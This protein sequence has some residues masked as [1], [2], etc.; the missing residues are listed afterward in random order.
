MFHTI[1]ISHLIN[2]P[3]KYVPVWVDRFEDM[4]EP[5]NLLFPHKHSFYE[6][7]WITKGKSNHTIDYKNYELEKNTL[8]FI[9]PGQLHLF[10][11]WQDIEG[12][13][14]LFTE[15]FFSQIFQNKNI[16]FELS[17]LDNLYSNPFLKIGDEEKSKLQPIVD[18][19]LKEKS[20]ESVQALLF[21]LL[22]QIQSLYLSNRA[23]KN[24]KNQIIIFKKFKNLVEQNFNK[25]LS[26]TEY[27]NQLNI[28]PN[29]LNSVVKS[30]CNKT[31]SHIIDERIVLEAKQLLQFSD[32]NI[33]QITD[34][35][36]F[37]DSSYFARYFKKHTSTSPLEFRKLHLR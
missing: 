26:L 30:I 10:E 11:D 37:E 15:G 29:T 23:N 16:L 14:I 36:G 6:I 22:K 12:Y 24:S 35:L 25:Y 32:D 8:F 17:Y 27:A 21:V 31:A 34:K 28:S 18:L 33:S 2:Q 1:S 5:Q 19:L 13:C 9:S 20:E 7:L 3:S 4:E